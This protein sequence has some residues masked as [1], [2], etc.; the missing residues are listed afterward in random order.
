[1]ADEHKG[2]SLV[3]LG[4]V[5]VIAVVGLVLLFTKAQSPTCEGIYCGAM[6]QISFPYW[7]GRGVPAN[8]PGDE[9][10]WPTTASKDLT[11]H[12]NYFGDPKRDPGTDVPS[13]MVKCGNGGFRVP[14]SDGLPEY[15][16]GEGYMVVETGDK[17]G[18][19][20]YPR[21]AMVGGIAGY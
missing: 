10:L 15:Y 2:I 12:W 17:A 4:I 11:T 9:A 20:V 6:K 1:M 18:L 5:A 8:R 16:R 21:T 19:C 13:P 3:I 7:V 14:Y